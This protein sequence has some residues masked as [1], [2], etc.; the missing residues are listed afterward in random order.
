MR[1]VAASFAPN[2]ATPTPCKFFATASHGTNISAQTS[3]PKYVE[4]HPAEFAKPAI[5]ARESLRTER[6]SDNVT[7]VSDSC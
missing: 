1:I 4:A 3:N 2:A 6:S 5:L 7:R